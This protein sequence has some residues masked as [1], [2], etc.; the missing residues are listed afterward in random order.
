MDG[1]VGSAL[2]P[3]SFIRYVQVSSWDSIFGPMVEQISSACTSVATSSAPFDAALH[4][5]VARQT[6]DGE[7]YRTEAD[8][9]MDIKFLVVPSFDL[10][11]SSIVFSA[12]PRGQS[13]KFSVSL[14][15][16]SDQLSTALRLQ[17][18]VDD[19]LT[20]IAAQ[21]QLLLNQVCCVALYSAC[22]NQDDV[23]CIFF[24]T[25]HDMLSP[26]HARLTRSLIVRYQC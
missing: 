7:I 11:M 3:N 23:V 21:L 22:R 16:S 26:Q 4:R 9:E 2:P 15:S 13:T 17:R 14:M 18:V 12:A 5:Y 19:R 1:V 20:A 25:F 24:S 8:A 10:V 6:L